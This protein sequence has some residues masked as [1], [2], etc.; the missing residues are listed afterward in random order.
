[1]TESVVGVRF[2][3]LGKLYHFR[4]AENEVGIDPGDH[5]IVETKRG[6]QL[7]Q[8]IAHIKPSRVDRR[9]G[10]KAIERKATP[11]DL[12]MRQV[13]EQKEL[14]ALITCREQAA[15][16][17]I[18]AV[19]FVKAEYSFDGSRLTLLY[20]TENKKLDIRPLRKNLR[21]I[22]RSRVEML[23]IGPRD[24]AKILGGHGACGHPRCCSTFLTEFSPISIRMAKAQGVSLSPQEITGM[25][26][27][28]R[29]CLVY[30][31]ELYVQA[32]KQLPKYGKVIGTPYGEGRVRDVRVLRDSV[33]VDVDGEYKEVFRHEFEPLDELRALEKKAEEG[34]SKK[35]NGECDCG[36]N[37]GSK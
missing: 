8:V 12:V 27:R 29:C 35:E 26:G 6:R 30:E 28:L 5:V 16:L 15:I 37:G 32:K 10:L 18:V 34:C 17:G 25:C 21:K 36:A 33:I 23:M 4:L 31:F 1:M 9:R 14:D 19:K 3:K 22:Y 20:A 24:V 2:Q 11:R 7:G 13:W